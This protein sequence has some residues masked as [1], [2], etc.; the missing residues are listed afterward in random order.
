MSNRTIIKLTKSFGFKPSPFVPTVLPING[1]CLISN[2]PNHVMAV[3]L[4]LLKILKFLKHILN[5]VMHLPLLLISAVFYVLAFHM[6]KTVWTDVFLKK[7]V[8]LTN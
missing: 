2:V 7:T 3:W 8:C 6:V 5:K 1:V 4:F